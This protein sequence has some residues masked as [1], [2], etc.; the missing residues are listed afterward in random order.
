MRTRQKISVGYPITALTGVPG[1]ID[2]QATRCSLYIQSLQISLSPLVEDLAHAAGCCVHSI[3]EIEEKD[4]SVL[5]NG[6]YAVF[7]F[8]DLTPSR[9]KNML[10]AR[11]APFVLFSGGDQVLSLRASYGTKGAR[12]SGVSL[13]VDGAMTTSRC[14][15]L[16]VARKICLSY[17]RTYVK[18][19]DD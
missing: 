18:E 17:I 5:S 16:S 7:D 8:L 12:I 2:F 11:W 9:R 6:T 3:E 1:V 10:S 14:T 13:K 15:N 19:P 4:E